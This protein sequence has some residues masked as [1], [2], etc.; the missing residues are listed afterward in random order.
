MVTRREI[1]QAWIVHLYTASGMVVAAVMAWSIIR[2]GEKGF[3]LAIGMMILATLIDA[4]DGTLA[5]RWRVGEILPGIDGRRL[6][7]I[8]DYQTYTSLPILFI[9]RSG[10]VPDDYG[11]WLL[12]PLLASLYGFV[13]TEAKTDDHFFRGFPSY[14]NVV[15][16]YLY[17]FELPVFWNMAIILSLAI[18]TFVP[19]LYLYPSYRG[20]Y[21]QLVRW[22]CL[23]W[24]ILLSLTVSGLF[25][26]PGPVVLISFT[27]PVLY[28]VLSWSITLR[29]WMVK[30]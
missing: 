5:R 6:D 29:R 27:F 2:G 24:G 30:K 9:W 20:Q 25:A 4:T 11:W 3:R 12:I 1:V 19:S 23:I 8:V 10:V 26:A 22:S 28:M 14:W 15:A 16:I 13:Q 7:D 17:W 18:L 21:S